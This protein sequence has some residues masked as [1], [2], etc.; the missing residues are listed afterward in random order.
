MARKTT[1]T[2]QEYDIFKT[3]GKWADVYRVMKTTFMDINDDES[4]YTVVERNITK[5]SV[6]MVEAACERM[7]N[8]TK[9]CQENDVK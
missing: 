4:N 2:D 7:K 5:N 6:I 1:A 8:S 9:R 3:Y